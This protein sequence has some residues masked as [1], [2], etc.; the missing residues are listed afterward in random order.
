[1]SALPGLSMGNYKTGIQITKEIP[2][3]TKQINNPSVFKE[4]L[5]Y[6][7]KTPYTSFRLLW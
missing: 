1:M 2:S 6:G 7:D 4:P 3:L 5:R